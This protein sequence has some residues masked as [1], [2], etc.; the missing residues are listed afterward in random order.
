[1][2]SKL[3]D[4]TLGALL[5][6]VLSTEISAALPQDQNVNLV[7]AHCTACHS[8]SLITQNRLSREAW[9]ETIRW[10]QKSQGL[11]P[12]G[13][14]EEPILDYLETHFSPKEQGRRPPIPAHLMPLEQ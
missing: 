7:R 8:E 3:K 2:L 11:W 1:M 13:A 14:H 5:F 10:M 12:L 9:L 4:F 6:S